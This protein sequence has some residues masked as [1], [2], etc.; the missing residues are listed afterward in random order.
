MRFSAEQ[1]YYA[2]YHSL[3]DSF[4]WMSKF[5]DRGWGHHRTVAQI[6]GAFGLRLADDA[7]IP[8][9][10]VDYASSLDLYAAAIKARAKAA[11]AAAVAAGA[12][13]LAFPFE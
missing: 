6:W 4:Y 2:V 3:Y 5:G 12:S 11:D 1:D 8:L 9:N 10:F 7:V 13:S